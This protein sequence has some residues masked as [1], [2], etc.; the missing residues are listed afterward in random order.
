MLSP[1]MPRRLFCVD[2]KR[3]RNK[4]VSGGGVIEGVNIY[5]LITTT[6]NSIY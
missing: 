2:H 5:I 1:F 3:I 6:I 4:R